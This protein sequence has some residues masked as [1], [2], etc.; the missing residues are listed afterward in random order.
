MLLELMNKKDAKFVHAKAKQGDIAH[1]CADITKAKR[2]LG[3]NPTH[4]LQRELLKLIEWY[5]ACIREMKKSCKQILTM[6]LRIQSACWNQ[7][8]QYFKTFFGFDGAGKS[9]HVWC[10]LS[11]Q[12][13]K[14]KKCWLHLLKLNI[15]CCLHDD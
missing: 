6:S 11:R 3:F 10:A 15:H 5:R 12:F 4:K 7:K 9:I 8:L 1:S 13:S 14:I 2:I